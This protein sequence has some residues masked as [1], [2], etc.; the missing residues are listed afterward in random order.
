MICSFLTPETRGRGCE[1]Q[2]ENKSTRDRQVEGGG[3]TVEREGGGTKVGLHGVSIQMRV[4]VEG[5]HAFVEPKDLSSV[6]CRW[7]QPA[8]RGAQGERERGEA[9]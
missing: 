1:T 7:W 9:R 5:V 6:C 3:G 4:F 8:V 2:T